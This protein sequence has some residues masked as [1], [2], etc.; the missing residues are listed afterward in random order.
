[1][2]DVK[3]RA[4]KTANGPAEDK[5]ASA[6]NNPAA[7][8]ESSIQE[9]AAQ[10]KIDHWR[11]QK[12]PDVGNAGYGDD[13]RD[14]VHGDALAAQH[15][16]HQDHNDCVGEA[17][18]NPQKPEQPGRI[19]LYRRFV[20]QRFIVAVGWGSAMLARLAIR[21]SYFAL[22]RFTKRLR[23]RRAMLGGAKA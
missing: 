17:V 10:A 2:P 20:G 5:T 9:R 23:Q 3:R 11:I 4:V 1:M 7:A 12:I 6:A 14:A 19:V 8:A 15:V 13:F 18:G 21:G 16:R 22:R